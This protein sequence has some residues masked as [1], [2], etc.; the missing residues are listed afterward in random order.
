MCRDCL[1]GN[2]A[3]W[4]GKYGTPYTKVLGWVGERYCGLTCGIGPCERVWGDVKDIK[5][6]KRSHIGDSIK[7]RSIL[8]TCACVEE[9]RINRDH[10]E[11]IDTTGDEA[12]FGDDDF[13]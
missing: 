6:G 4:H 8:Y 1:E 7:K 13:K 11:R 12:M 10:M 3:D 9:A 5:T 2:S